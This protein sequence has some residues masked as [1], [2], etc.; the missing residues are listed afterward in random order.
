MSKPSG[1]VSPSTISCSVCTVVF[2]L[3]AVPSS[4]SFW[5]TAFTF[6]CISDFPMSFAFPPMR[7]KNLGSSNTGTER[8]LKHPLVGTEPLLYLGVVTTF[9]LMREPNF[10]SW[11]RG[12]HLSTRVSWN[13]LQSWQRN[14]SV[15]HFSFQCYTPIWWWL[16]DVSHHECSP[17]ISEG[18]VTLSFF[19]DTLIQMKKNS[20]SGKQWTFTILN[21]YKGSLTKFKKN[22]T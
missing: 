16:K 20:N 22:F 8:D 14:F 21:H 6:C 4:P 15:N 17:G 12:V 10:W 19:I 5:R 3:L 11:K 2:S 7:D 13:G 18:S 9:A 1:W